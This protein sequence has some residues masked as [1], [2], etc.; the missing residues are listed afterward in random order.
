MSMRER[1]TSARATTRAKLC[2]AV[3]AFGVLSIP[4]CKPASTDASTTS[5]S[6]AL[7]SSN[8]AGAAP[9]CL[10]ETAC[11]MFWACVSVEPVGGG[12]VRYLTHGTHPALVGTTTGVGKVSWKDL[13]GG[14]SSTRAVLSPLPCTNVAPALVA[15]RF[16]CTF[17]AGV[18]VATE[19]PAA[20]AIHALQSAKA[21]VEASMVDE[22]QCRIASPIGAAKVDL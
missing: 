6:T 3:V 8:D 11:N 5:A 14:A 17:A 1:D 15:P 18:C 7:Q 19:T 22:K 10:P 21:V 20:P 16:T 13:D 4:S 2:I 9:E 12:K